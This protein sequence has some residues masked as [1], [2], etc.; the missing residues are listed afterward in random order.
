MQA[1]P[2]EPADALVLNGDSSNAGP[3]GITGSGVERYLGEHGEDGVEWAIV[4][5]F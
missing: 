2:T 4:N 3:G 5:G 1:E